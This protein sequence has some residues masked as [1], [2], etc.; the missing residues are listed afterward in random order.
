[1][2]V[3]FY[4]KYDFNKRIETFLALFRKIG[5]SVI[6]EFVYPFIVLSVFRQEILYSTIV[7]GRFLIYYCPLVIRLFGK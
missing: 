3:V 5:G 6:G 1:M 4:L 7:I 2:L